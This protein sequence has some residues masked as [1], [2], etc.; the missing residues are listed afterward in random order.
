LQAITDIDAHRADL[1]TQLAIDAIAM[2]LRQPFRLRP[3]PGASGNAA[4]VAF[5]TSFVIVHREGFRF[6]HDALE[7]A[8]RTD[9]S[10]DMFTQHTGREVS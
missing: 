5:S 4:R 7:A 1:D 8:I 3:C 6:V 10:A 9:E 2:S